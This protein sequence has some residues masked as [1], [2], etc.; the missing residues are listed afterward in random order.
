MQQPHTKGSSEPILTSSHAPAVVTSR[1]KRSTE[2]QMGGVLSREITAPGRRRCALKRQATRA[3]TLTRVL[4]RQSAAGRRCSI[5]WARRETF[6]TRTG[7]PRRCLSATADRWVK[8]IAVRPTRT[9]V[10]RQSVAVV[11]NPPGFSP[12]APTPGAA[13]SCEA[14][15]G[16][17]PSLRLPR[18]L[19][20]PRKRPHASG[21]SEMDRPAET[22]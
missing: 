16:T 18:C 12:P 14:R 4:V 3:G 10:D 1:V 9:H 22:D 5:L 19:R 21:A 13:C 8:A 15:A 11:A 2:A 17:V 20:T 6:C 7:R